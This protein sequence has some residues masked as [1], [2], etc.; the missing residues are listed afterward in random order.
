[1]FYGSWWICGGGE[2]GD[3]SGL[4]CSEKKKMTVAKRRRFDY[5]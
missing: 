5:F 1:V 2:E 4:V 3:C